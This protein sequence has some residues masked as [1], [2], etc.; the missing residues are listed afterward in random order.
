MIGE[1]PDASPE[2]V[3]EACRAARD[4]FEHGAWPAMSGAER[5]DCLA[6]AADRIERR[7][8]E[9]VELAMA[10]TGSTRAHSEQSQV[11]VAIERLRMYAELARE[12][13]EIPMPPLEREPI[14]GSSAQLAA[15]VTTRE[16]VGV[17][18]CICPSNTPVTNCAGKIGPA[19]AMGDTVV[20]KPPVQ[21]PLG[22]AELARELTTCFP[23]GV[24]SYVA[25]R[26]PELG[27][28]LVAHPDVDMISFTGSTHVGRRI[29]EVGG[30]TMK[31]L[32]LELGGKSASI[33]FG[34]CDVP[35]AIRNCA[36]T[37]TFHSGQ[38]CIA[39]TRLLVE[40]AF[41][42]EFVSRMA[43]HGRSLRVGSAHDPETIVGPMISERHLN[44]VETLVERSLAEGAEL[45]CGGRRPP[46]LDKGYFYEPTLLT[47]V[48]NEMKIAQEEVFGPVIVAM[49]FDDEDEAI[50]IA[51][52]SEFGL[53][54]YVWSGDTARGVRI[55]KR[56]RSGTIQV[57]G[58]PP[59][60]WAP[61]GGFKQSGVGR[62]G[63]RYGLNAYS[64]LK[65]V[66]WAC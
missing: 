10:E 41:F 3:S 11:G 64:E 61:F 33:V 22:M 65:Y 39:P 15:G 62:D 21:D 46:E 45:A 17:V 28:A 57:N 49:P 60:P 30:R 7:A 48:D 23:A 51:N 26:S 40:R 58:S 14:A 53:Y 4:A 36:T 29:A 55:A 44:H 2:Q 8:P 43:E 24:V 18:A 19:L 63:G 13:H 6:A 5:G 27:E 35:G 31:R 16:P 34:D 9:L 25:G 42:D 66:G 37:W 59:N 54:G 56:V 52:D 47:Q 50:R 20:L 1:A 12:T 32:L 38:M